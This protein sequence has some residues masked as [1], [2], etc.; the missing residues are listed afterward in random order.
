MRMIRA[1][2]ERAMRS[3]VRQMEGGVSAFVRQAREEITALL[4]ALAAAVD[5][6][7]EVE[8]TQTAQQGYGQLP[9]HRRALGRR[10]RR[11]RRPH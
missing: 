4:A 9:R 1:G 10:M 6:P 2:S 8:E 3:A 11:A 7:D 5:F